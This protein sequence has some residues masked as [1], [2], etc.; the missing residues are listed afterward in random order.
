[1][2]RIFRRTCRVRRSIAG[3]VGWTHLVADASSHTSYASN[4]RQPIHSLNLLPWREDSRP[5]EHHRRGF[6]RD[7]PRRWRAP[8]KMDHLSPLSPRHL[9][10]STNT[11]NNGGVTSSSLSFSPSLFS[12]R[13]PL[14]LSYV[15]LAT[16]LF[17]PASLRVVFARKG[18]ESF[19]ASE[20]G[21]GCPHR[22]GAD[23]RVAVVASK[24]ASGEGALQK[25]TLRP[26]I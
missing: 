11:T 2:R 25:P 3:G 17:S 19:R 16:G 8:M 23:F 15:T 13:S 10:S 12:F 4:P 18:R 6:A 9:S 22:F 21:P 5:F 14:L 20:G 26:P 24:N 1:M 7:G